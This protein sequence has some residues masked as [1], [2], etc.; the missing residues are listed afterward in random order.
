[1]IIQKSKPK[2]FK[3]VGNNFIYINYEKNYTIYANR[4]YDYFAGTE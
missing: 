4:F 3:R 1:M 2:I